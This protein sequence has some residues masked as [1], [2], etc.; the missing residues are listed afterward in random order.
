MQAGTP[1]IV[2]S[3]VDLSEDWTTLEAL[4]YIASKRF[5]LALRP[6]FMFKTEVKYGDP[7]QR[8]CWNNGFKVLHIRQVYMYMCPPGDAA[9]LY[10]DPTSFNGLPHYLQ[11]NA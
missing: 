6:R 9:A 7:V 3:Q 5:N 11:P 8:A 10:P 2:I 1:C 4:E